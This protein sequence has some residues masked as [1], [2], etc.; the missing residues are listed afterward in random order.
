MLL[1]PWLELLLLYIALELWLPI[2]MFQ[3]LALK[4]AL[5]LV[6]IGDSLR[7]NIKKGEL[8]TNVSFVMS[9]LSQGTTVEKGKLW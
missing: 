7:L 3:G 1:P 4:L 5:V 9:Y 2:I 8:E 6:E